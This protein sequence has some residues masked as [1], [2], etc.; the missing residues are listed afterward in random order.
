MPTSFKP[1]A[2]LLRVMTILLLIAQAPGVHAEAP[3][4]GLVKMAKGTVMIEREQQALPAAVGMPVLQSDV[5]TT[6]TDGSAGISFRDNSLL[7]LG[8][9]SRLAVDTFRFDSTTHEG[10]FETTLSKGRMAV[11]SGKIAKHQLDAMKVRTPTALLGVRGT[12]FI[13]EAGDP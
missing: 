9:R 13:V 10:V 4:V 11:V 8:P 3:A 2:V 7:S 6:G 12:E 1:I 5:I